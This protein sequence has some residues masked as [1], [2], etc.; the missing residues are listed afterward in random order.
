M[1]RPF[2]VVAGLLWMALISSAT[3]MK[4]FNRNISRSR[5][6]VA[7]QKPERRA[8]KQKT[9]STNEPQSVPSA[10]DNQ[11]PPSEEESSDTA[12]KQVQDAQAHDSSKRS[13]NR[14][15]QKHDFHDAY[16]RGQLIFRSVEL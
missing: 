7:H 14:N 4:P 11:E 5:A 3:A 12:D 13:R 1:G 15:P 10:T 9:T 8:A 16:R 2:L 6:F